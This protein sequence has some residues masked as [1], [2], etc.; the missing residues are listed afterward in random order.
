M[1]RT[2]RRTTGRQPVWLYREYLY[3]F[4]FTVVQDKEEI[5]KRDIEWHSDWGYRNIGPSKWFRQ[6]QEAG[7]RSYAKEEI[8]KFWK[9]RD[10]EIQITN[11]QRIDYWD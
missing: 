6:N 9:D 3:G 4:G 8:I 7:F 1:A 11:K 5:K 2:K 10:Y